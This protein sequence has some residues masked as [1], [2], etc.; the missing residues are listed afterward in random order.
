MEPVE[1]EDIEEG[2]SGETGG[3]LVPST[4]TRRPIIPI[5][6]AEQ[7]QHLNAIIDA[8]N[9]QIMTVINEQAKR[10]EAS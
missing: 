1:H 8:K 10:F 4:T 9:N 5:F 3:E 7:F 2:L 6:S